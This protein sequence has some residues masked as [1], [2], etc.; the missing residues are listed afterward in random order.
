MVMT[1]LSLSYFSAGMQL[2]ESD[3]ES[4]SGVK[5]PEAMDEVVEVEAQEAEA[6]E[7]DEQ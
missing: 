1:S 7:D 4:S 2:R 5:L 3:A 6:E